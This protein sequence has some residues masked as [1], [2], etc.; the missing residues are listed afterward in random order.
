MNADETNLNDMMRQLERATT[1]EPDRDASSDPQTAALREGWTLLGQLLQAAETESPCRVAWE[2]LTIPPPATP[3][4]RLAAWKVPAA[5][6]VAASLLL[7]LALTW[8][9]WRTPTGE[10]MAKSS[11]PKTETHT[12]AKTETVLADLPWDEPIDTEI[13][14][15]KRQVLAVE[16]EWCFLSNATYP[17]YGRLQEI[18]QEMSDGSM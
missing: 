11:A 16:Q 4:T 17:V 10:S 18:Q 8:S 1:N 12:Q 15:A 5:L 7:G 9:F 6:A 3:A 2:E 14:Q 13:A